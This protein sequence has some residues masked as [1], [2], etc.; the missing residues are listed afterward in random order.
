MVSAKRLTASQRPLG[1]RTN[2]T[3]ISAISVKRSARKN[4]GGM[5]SAPYLLVTN[6]KPQSRAVP[7][8]I[9]M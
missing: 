3:S 1:G 6:P 7:T 8:A 2:Q 9:G 4:S 5:W